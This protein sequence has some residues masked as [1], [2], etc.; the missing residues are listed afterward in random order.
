M[1]PTAVRRDWGGVLGGPIV[2]NKA[3][4]FF[5]LERQVD[6]PNRTRPFESRPDLNFAIAED[7]TDW[8]TLIRFDHQ[9]NPNHTWAV[10]WLREMGAAVEH[11][12]R[13][14]RRCNRFRTR[15]TWTRPRSAR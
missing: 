12:R 13:R 5:S 8:N 2:K 10:R 11:G 4:F 1:K 14:V 3:H 7:R 15:P 9:I 6:N